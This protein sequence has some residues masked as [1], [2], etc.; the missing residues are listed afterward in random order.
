MKKEKKSFMSWPLAAILCCVGLFPVGAVIAVILGK[1][2]WETATKKERSVLWCGIG[3]VIFSAAMLGYFIPFI[4]AGLDSG[5]LFLITC[6]IG[7]LCGIG[8]IVFYVKLSDR[9]G[10]TALT[11]SVIC[12]EHIT[13]I[14]DISNICGM[15]D[16]ESEKA[17][18]RLL[19]SG[20][21][22]E[23]T[24]DR[25]HGTVEFI[26]S[27]WVKQLMICRDCGAEV[28]V[29]RGE[30]LVCEYCGSALFAKEKSAAKH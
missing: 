9:A 8:M 25:S 12:D 21:L 3:S 28:L 23:A 14:Y 16:A 29:L 1:K 15:N 24:I 26:R 5:G 19:A 2:E 17:I 22:P 10:K 7:L 30:T 20:E 27:P 6:A 11:L 4:L 13:R 18:E